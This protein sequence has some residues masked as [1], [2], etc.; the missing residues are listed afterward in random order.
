M[1]RESNNRMANPI[2]RQQPSPATVEAQPIVHPFN[3][4]AL[5]APC[6]GRG[7]QPVVERRKKDGR[8]DCRCPSCGKGFVYTPPVTRVKEPGEA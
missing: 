6:C 4:P 5:I 1:T 8:A 7:I 2:T 3:V